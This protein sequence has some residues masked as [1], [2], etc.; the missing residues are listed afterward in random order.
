MG[1]RVDKLEWNKGSMAISSTGNIGTQ[2]WGFRCKPVYCS[3]PQLTTEQ[4]LVPI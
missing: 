2:G 1:A 3:A 4:P